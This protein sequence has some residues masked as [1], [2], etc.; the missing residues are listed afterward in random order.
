MKFYI[1]GGAVRDELL[2]VKSK[3]IDYAVVLD[4]LDQTVQ[5]GFAEMEAWLA[6]NGYVAFLSTPDC[7]TVRAKFPKGHVNE[8]LVADFV[9][10]RKENGYYEGTRKPI[11]TMGILYDDLVRRDF[12]VNS[13]AKDEEGN[14]IDLFNGV[15]DLKNKVLKTPLP[16][17]I[18]MMDDPLRILRCLRFSITKGFMIS[19]EIWYAMKQPEILEK[20]RNVVSADRIRQE[21]DK[22]MRFDTTKTLEIFREVEYFIPGFTQLVFSRGLWL[23][24][25]FEKI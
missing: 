18:T 21:V 12:S 9:M 15:E 14:L 25:T 20:L 13:M 22:M 8:N 11:L 24:P 2:G 19:E 4:N 23:K 3:D 16:A 7:F 1:V 5:E 17:H 6:N 10:A